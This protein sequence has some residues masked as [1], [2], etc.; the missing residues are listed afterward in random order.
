[1]VNAAAVADA[2]DRARRLPALRVGLHLALVDGTPLLPPD[3]VPDLVDADGVLRTD[4]ARLGVEIFFRSRSRRQVAAEIEAQFAAFRA[5]GLALDHVNAHHHFHAHP[6]VAAMIL[7]IGRRYG[8]RALR[9]PAEPARVLDRIEHG[10]RSRRDWRIAPW[11]AL[12]R[13]R[14]R[15]RG[16]ATTDQVF[17][18]AWSGAMTEARVGGI[19]RNLPEGVT[20]I[21]A[22]PATTDDFRGSVPGCRYADELAALVAPGIKAL[23]AAC[24]ARSGGFADVCSA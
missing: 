11:M 23:A 18:L 14:A 10:A 9:V 2:V 5:T 13:K 16:L 7:D 6:T 21:Y 1:M 12:L 4:L 19:L 24:G 15:A 3:R 8:L 17:G 22:H 20:E